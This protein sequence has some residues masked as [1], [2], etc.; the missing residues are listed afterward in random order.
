MV[1]VLIYSGLTWNGISES[2]CHN[3]TRSLAKNNL[4]YYLEVPYCYGNDRPHINHISNVSI[5]ENVEVISHRSL[6]SDVTYFIPYGLKYLFRAQFHSLRSF[7]KYHSKFKVAILYNVYDPLFLLLCKL[8]GKKIVYAIVDDYPELTPNNLL[9]TLL[10]WTEK[11]FLKLK[12][13]SF[14]TAKAL[15][16]K[17][18]K[19][20]YIPN[21]VRTIT[22]PKD[23]FTFLR[24]KISSYHVGILGSL[25]QWIDIESINYAAKA[26]PKVKFHVIGD[27]PRRKELKKLPNIIQYGQVSKDR[28]QQLLRKMN[29]ALICFKINKITNSVSPVKMFEYWQYGLPIIASPTTELSQYSDILSYYQT[30]QGLVEEINYLKTFPEIGVS[31]GKK[32]VKYLKEHNWEKEGYK[33]ERLIKKVI[34]R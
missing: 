23:P 6:F 22:S 16:Y 13:T 1:K 26:L 27:G 14:V 30:P 4:V 33:Y 28:V 12:D 8:F 31:K 34:R 9:K 5:P 20:T 7:F 25:G 18:K 32:G 29:V 24:D 21:M 15:K 19:T 3:L 17:D 10:T 2:H 11:L